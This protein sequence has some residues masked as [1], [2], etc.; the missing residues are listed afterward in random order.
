VTPDAHPTR[1]EAR[2]PRLWT[3]EEANARLPAIQELLPQL[4][5][6]V[7]RLGAIHDQTE[8]MA[9]FWGRELE[10]P[11]NPHHALQET[12]QEEWNRLTDRLEGI[13]HSL[14]DEGIEIK[15]LDNGLVDFQAKRDGD[16]VYLCWRD[17]EPIVAHWHPLDGGYRNRRRLDA[18]AKAGSP[19]HLTRSN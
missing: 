8:W 18:P 14:H 4:R 10:A 13:V 12:L 1:I 6:W 3:V 9:K 17:G 7:V 15:D 2:V 11:D 19:P 16:V 5:A